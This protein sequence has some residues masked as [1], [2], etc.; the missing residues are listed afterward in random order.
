MHQIN[1][2]MYGS[3]GGLKFCKNSKILWHVF[4]VGTETDI[5]A[6]YFHG[7]EFEI[8]GN[9]KDSLTLFPGM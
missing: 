7:N 3:L 8:E 5:H 1:G 2:K 6:V 4:V 9:H